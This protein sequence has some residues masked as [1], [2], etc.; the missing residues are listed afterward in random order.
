MEV[1]IGKKDLI[2]SYIASLVSLSS[3]IIILPLL[4]YFLTADTLGLWYLFVSIGSISVLFDFGFAVTFARSIT[5]SWCGANEIKKTGLVY[6]ESNEPNYGLM[7]NILTTCKRIYFAISLLLLICLLTIGTAY[8]CYQIRNLDD[9]TNLYAWLIYCIAIYLNLYYNYYSSFLRGVGAVDKA[10]R[11]T[12]I[13]RVLQISLMIILLF[14]GLGILGLAIAYLV[15]GISFRLLCKHQFYTYKDIG[16]NL[17]EHKKLLSFKESLE[18]FK[19]IWYN[20]WR[21]GLIQLSMY[22]SGQ[23]TVIICSFF[24]PLS[25]TGVYSLSM[26]MI[27]ALSTLASI[28]YVAF[29]PELQSECINRR[30]DKIRLTMSKIVPFFTYSFFAG[31]ILIILVAVPIIEWIKP[32]LV[33]S[34]PLIIGLGISQYLI[35]FRNC[36]SSYFSSTNRV[37][38]VKSYITAS[39]VGI[40]L[41]I[42]F[43]GYLRIGAWGVVLATILSQIMFNAWYWPIKAH[44]E[45]GF[46]L[47]EMFSMGNT[48]FLSIMKNYIHRK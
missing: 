26:Q 4:V 21:D 47:K 12:V 48:Y 45:L 19:T 16:V 39:I 8:I 29:Q 11:S 10:N 14:A 18:I 31:L 38:Y 15:Y 41:G 42:L 5:Y 36:Y 13:S 9:K 25:Q 43:M 46:S 22:L 3:N 20:A 28:L 1:K 2:W 44:K 27:M 33:L 17:K 30:I 6:S 23:A 37:I 32:T 7:G 24:L 40:V 34:V 35:Q